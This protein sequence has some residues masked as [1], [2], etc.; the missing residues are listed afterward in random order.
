LLGA[1]AALPV[2]VIVGASR[3]IRPPLL[4]PGPPLKVHILL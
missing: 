2:I 1:G 4:E 3:R